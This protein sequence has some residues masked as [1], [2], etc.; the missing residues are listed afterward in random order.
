MY[1]KGIRRIVESTMYE[2][3]QTNRQKL[4]GNILNFVFG[5]KNQYFLSHPLKWSK[6]GKNKIFIQKWFLG[7]FMQFSDDTTSWDNHHNCWWLQHQKQDALKSLKLSCSQNCCFYNHQ[8]NSQWSV[9][10]NE[11]IF[12]Y[13]WLTLS[14][15][16]GL[17]FMSVCLIKSNCYSLLYSSL[18]CIYHCW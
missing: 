12:A 18:I 3:Y 14:S 8:E 11:S 10:Q 6:C 15:I 16:F 17:Y 13:F 5:L 1:L 2:F 4:S 7:N 9:R